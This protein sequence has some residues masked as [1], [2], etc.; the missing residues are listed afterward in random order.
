[1]IVKGESL[2]E[3]ADK[4]VS[5]TARALW[6]MCAK[7]LAFAFSF[8]LPLLLVRR[9]DQH[10][11]GLYKQV[12]LVVSTA[13]ALLP[14][15]FA[16]SA[17]YFLP[18]EPERG[19][20]VAL[21]ILIFNA[22]VGAA[23][24][25]LLCLRPDLLGALFRSRELAAYAPS[26]GA[27]VMLWI[28]ASFLEYIAIANQEPRVATVFIVCAQ[29]TK[30]T[31]LL[32]AALFFSTVSALVYAA[33]I[34]GALQTVVLLCYLRS[35][36][37]GFLRSFEWATMRRQLAYA[38]PLGLAAMLY[39]VQTDLHNYV[40]SYRFGAAAFAVYALGCFDLPLV[41]I[42]GESVGSVMIPRVSYLQH[43]GEH[44]EILAVT[45]RAMRKLAAVFLPLYALMFVVRREFIVFL[46]TERYAASVPV[47]AV[48]LTLLPFSIFVL[49][50]VM[51]AYAEHRYFLL[52]VRPF[53]IA[54]MAVALWY[55]TRGH[56]L[57]AAVSVMVGV[58]VFERLIAAAKVA[59]I[60]RMTR[61][62]LP[63]FKDVA[64]IA[65]ASAAAGAAAVAV[66]AALAGQR[67][68]TVLCACGVGFTLI[69]LAAAIMLGVP[70]EGERQTLRGQVVR[71]RRRVLRARRADAASAADAVVRGETVES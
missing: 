4:K 37:P 34:Q 24:C 1:M 26:V 12:F 3:A 32:A 61:R 19:P 68:F 71:L 39:I 18:R 16:M 60:V 28:V 43:R 36:F 41:N 13:V 38:M 59:S 7:T 20:H 10:E 56:G 14:L 33:I 40:V 44:H 53:L 8:A 48:N 67:P 55:V 49:D 51:R 29:L 62:D 42:L 65:L 70:T 11:F 47:F 58:M 64:K 2:D 23:A 25:L 21:N 46:F 45:A 66:R 22:T 15:G 31:L 52:K 63:Q 5:L 50:P 9:L 17:F 69:Y 27:V 6:L 30:T 54:L 35:R 57:V